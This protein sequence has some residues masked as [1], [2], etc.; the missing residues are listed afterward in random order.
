T[1]PSFE[2]QADAALAVMDA[3]KIEQVVVMGFSGG[4]PGTIQFGLRNPARCRGM[5]LMSA[6]GPGTLRVFSAWLFA[7]VARMTEVMLTFDFPMWLLA[8]IP[9][10]VP[11]FLLGERMENL[12]DPSKL[13]M[14]QT[15]LDDG[16]PP[17]DYKDGT[18]NDIVQVA[19][20]RSQPEW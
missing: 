14:V 3:L 19:R 8:H 11:L 12:R 9:V 6:H 2:S 16:F 5:V 20:L 10:Q 17:S 13:E 18:V 15:I 7:F 1:G 4:G